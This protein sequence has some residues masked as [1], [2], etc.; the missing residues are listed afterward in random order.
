MSKPQGRGDRQGLLTQDGTQSDHRAKGRD[1]RW[2]R[3]TAVLSLQKPL[4]L[5]ASPIDEGEDRDALGDR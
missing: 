3:E 1:R 4:L 2:T 5:L